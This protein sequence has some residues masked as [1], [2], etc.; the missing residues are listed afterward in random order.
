[1][2]ARCVSLKLIDAEASSDRPTG[3]LPALLGASLWNLPSSGVW[4]RA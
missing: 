3:A 1:M 2:T 4:T